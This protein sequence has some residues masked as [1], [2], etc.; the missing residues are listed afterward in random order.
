M[1]KGIFLLN[2]KL[3]VMRKQ[4]LFVL[5]IMVSAALGSCKKCYDCTKK[6]G[7]CTLGFITVAG[8]EG[9][10]VLEGRS[11]ESYKVY[12][13]SQGYTCTFNNQT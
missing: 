1:Q 2:I 11:I 6:C 9:D 13:E 3:P 4:F 8:C 10:A 12:F 7:T 5:L